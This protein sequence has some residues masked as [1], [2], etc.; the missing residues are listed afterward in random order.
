MIQIC[1]MN[2]STDRDN[3]IPRAVCHDGQVWWIMN[4]AN[5]LSE[6]GWECK[7]PLQNQKF[8][9]LWKNACRQW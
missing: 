9:A 3:I 1:M 4:A 7:L 5:V 6:T 8:F 2:L